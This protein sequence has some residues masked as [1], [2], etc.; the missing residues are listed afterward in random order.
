MLV[1][2]LG[3]LIEVREVSP[4]KALSPIDVTES[5]I[6]MEVRDVLDRKALLPIDVRPEG[7][8]NTMEFRVVIL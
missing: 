6:V 4:R 5:G 8:A 7:A 1:T 2:P 3:I